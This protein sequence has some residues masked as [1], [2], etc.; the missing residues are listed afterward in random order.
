[1]FYKSKKGELKKKYHD[2]KNIESKE[3]QNLLS[4]MTYHSFFK[5]KCLLHGIKQIPSESIILFNLKFCGRRLLSS[6]EN[7]LNLSKLQMVF[8]Y[9]DIFNFIILDY[10]DVNRVF[11]WIWLDTYSLILQ[12][13]KKAWQIPLF[14]SLVNYSLLFFYINYCF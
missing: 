10:S 3:I 12:I 9:T 5:M 4:L 11:N 1:M 7:L 13:S 8:Q 14:K 2:L 6:Y